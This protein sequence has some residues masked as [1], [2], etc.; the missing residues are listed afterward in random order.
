MSPIRHVRRILVPKTRGTIKSALANRKQRRNDRSVEAR[1][2]KL[3]SDV[4]HVASDVG[5]VHADVRE[6]RHGLTDMRGSVTASVKDVADKL[7]KFADET[8]VGLRPLA[9]IDGPVASRKFVRWSAWAAFI[10]LAAIIL[11]GGSG[12]LL[13]LL[14]LL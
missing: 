11:L 2:A 3:E 1:L 13:R 9:N 7:D 10:A 6:L 4:A 5:E 12:A 14:K 8:R